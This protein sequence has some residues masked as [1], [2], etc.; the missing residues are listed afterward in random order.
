MK[1]V[2]GIS[3][4]E[5]KSVGRKLS[6]LIILVL[7]VIM[8]VKLVYDGIQTYNNELRL[9]E[10]LRREEVRKLS[11]ITHGTFSN[12][13][14]T[15]KSIQATI[16]NYMSQIPLQYRNR[17]NL[18]KTIISIFQQN[19]DIMMGLGIFFEPN[20]F[21]TNGRFS[22]NLLN[23]NGDIKVVGDPDFSGQWYTDV[24]AKGI[25][26]ITDP[27]KHSQ[28]PIASSISAPIKY[29]GKIIGVCV[30]DI[31][32][33][34]IN[35]H[36]FEL[37]KND[38]AY[39]DIISNKGKIIANSDNPSLIGEDA[40]ALNKDLKNI[41]SNTLQGEEIIADSVNISGKNVKFITTPLA[42]AGTDTKWVYVL[43][44][45]VENFTAGART[46]VVT[47]IVVNIFI[48]LVIAALIYFLVEKYITK[49]LGYVK[50]S[51]I[52]MA[53]YNFAISDDIKKMEKYQNN[54]D[55]ISALVSAGIIMNR[56]IKTLINAIASDAQNL[57]ATSEELSATSQTTL[58]SA[59]EVSDAVTNIAHGATSQ[60]TDT[61]QASTDIQEVQEII[62]QTIN[63]MQELNAS[64]T[65]IN[66]KKNQGQESLANLMQLS[67]N[68][69][70]AAKE[71]TSVILDANKS[72]D[73]ISEASEMI[74]SISDQTNLLALNAAIEAARAGEAGRGFAV[75]ADEI[76][77][78]AEQ[79]AGFTTDIKNVIEDLKKK[80]QE[81][82]N[83]MSGVGKLVAEQNENA[84]E[85]QNNFY[86]IADAVSVSEDIIHKITDFSAKIEDKNNNL[87]SVIQNLSAIA[88]ENAATT[89]QASASV[90]SQTH[91]I[92]EIL[93][94]SENLA[95]RA[96]DLQE[97]VAKFRI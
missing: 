23:E 57:A 30:A 61:T 46:L 80:T 58:H 14:V 79:S 90:E 91:S 50:D 33:T 96:T 66:E 51:F 35:N 39:I 15:L 76:R 74:Q 37:M 12:V 18:R 13:N 9:A 47:S 69:N 88:Q 34:T 92:N 70:E 20:T 24:I 85:T 56:N 36:L 54:S 84:T 77:N 1:K 17:E 83:T 4:E 94:A 73:K 29:Q 44:D 41:V 31:N 48:V 10:N 78:L 89:Q 95:T 55:D 81:A 40:F 72:A 26:I 52:K 8:S 62:Q 63:H 32:L 5:V 2:N 19:R 21:D 82:V 45:E 67:H 64:V 11:A 65:T 6:L 42:I 53:N 38:N 28:G 75:V 87:V 49:P 97:L 71:M 43:V 60:A 59:Q 22:T 25:K 16:D 7:A 3:N 68:N 93:S 27:Y 86:Q